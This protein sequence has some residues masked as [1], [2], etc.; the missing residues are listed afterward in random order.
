MRPPALDSPQSYCSPGRASATA[1]VSSRA[2]RR[3]RS[4]RER[5]PKSGMMAVRYDKRG[6]GQSG[7]R[8]ESATV[9]D[10]AEDV[11]AVVRWL[12]KR[13]DVD[14]KRIAVVGH[15]EGAWVGLLAASRERRIAAVVSI[16]GPSTTGAELVLEQQRLALEQTEVAGRG[17]RQENRPSA[18]DPLGGADR[19]GLGHGARLN[20]AKRPTHP[21]SKACWHSIRRRCST[22]FASRCCSCMAR[23]TVRFP[24]STSSAC[25]TWR[26][27]RASR[28]RSRWSSF[29]A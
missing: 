13:P 26:A 20:C 4:W 18:A 27:R 14:P 17:A 12:E 8:S 16:A 28:S 22:M 19:Q 11:R 25:R 9:S 6:N 2:S 21:G 23:W 10:F 7:G 15:S 29:A 24:W 3:W 1:T 5:S